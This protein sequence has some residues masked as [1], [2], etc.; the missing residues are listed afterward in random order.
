M[1]GRSTPSFFW[2]TWN[3]S[4]LFVRSFVCVSSKSIQSSLWISCFN[5]CWWCWRWLFK[6]RWCQFFTRTRFSCSL[7]RAIP[8]IALH[9]SRSNSHCPMLFLTLFFFLIFLSSLFGRLFLPSSLAPLLNPTSR[10]NFSTFHKSWDFALATFFSVFDWLCTVKRISDFDHLRRVYVS[11]F[12]F[13][14][15][16]MIFKSLFVFNSFPSISVFKSVFSSSPKNP[17][18][19]SFVLCCVTGVVYLDCLT[20]TFKVISAYRCTCDN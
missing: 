5:S 7:F 9:I 13:H 17:G 14:R 12:V 10:P 15:L 18:L 2:W 16:L 20:T 19:L 3:D 8:Q 11:R 1:Y 6:T 4:H